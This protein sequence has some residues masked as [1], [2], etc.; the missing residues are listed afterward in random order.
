[1]AQDII[2]PYNFIPLSSWVFTPDWSEHT[3]HDIPFS[4]GI[5]GKINYK[6]VNS[7]P[8]CVGHRRDNNKVIWEK[9][10]A[11]EYIIPGSS[12]KGLL[13]TAMEIVSYGKMNM[14]HNKKHS[15]RLQ[16]DEVMGSNSTY[17]RLPVL[18]RP[19]KSCEGSWEY[20]E[21]ITISNHKP[22][23]A[24]VNDNILTKLGV[25]RK[26]PATDK[27]K[28]LM[29][30]A[31]DSSHMPLVYAK[32]ADCVKTVKQSGKTYTVTWKEVVD[33]SLEK[34]DEHNMPGMFLF[35]NE[36]I[37]NRNPLKVNKYTD[38]FFYIDDINKLDD[39]SKWKKFSEKSRLMAEL[40]ES[41]PAVKASKDG[42]KDDNLFDYYRKHMHPKAG[43]PVWYLFDESNESNSCTGFC[44]VMRKNYN[45]SIGKLITNQQSNV[46]SNKPDLPETIFGYTGLGSDVSSS[47]GRVGFSDL[48]GGTGINCFPREFILGEPK[49]SFYPVYLGRFIFRKPYDDNSLI[50]G[51]KIYKI[52]DKLAN[53]N[54]NNNENVKTEVNFIG[55]GAEFS[56]SITFH[57]LKPEELG[58]ILWV[59]TFG[60]G[61]TESSE[62]YHTLG[63]AKPMGAGAIQF[64]LNKNSIEIP[65]YMMDGCDV[66]ISDER[67][68]KDELIEKCI[69]RFKKLMNL[70]FPFGSKDNFNEW[71]NS[72]IMQLYL[73]YS[74][75]DK[76]FN[77][78]K[79]YNHF[80]TTKNEEGE[81]DI[82]EFA[83]IQKDFYNT[84]KDK[85]YPGSNPNGK[86]SGDCVDV[87][88]S[89][90]K[91]NPLLAEQRKHNEQLRIEK[92]KKIHEAEEKLKKE[93]EEKLKK[94]K[95][96][97]EKIEASL[98]TSFEQLK[99]INRE[100]SPEE[101][102][103]SVI[104]I[105]VLEKA[106]K[107][108]DS[109]LK[110]GFDDVSN[111]NQLAKNFIVKHQLSDQTIEDVV[112]CINNS[113]DKDFIK[114][115]KDVC[116]KRKDKDAFKNLEKIMKKL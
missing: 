83:I 96:E 103:K 109:V 56:G 89:E 68:S 100:N 48:S 33:F 29:D 54:C 11:G 17:T 14:F 22:L 8:I 5:S 111:F 37:S 71:E 95:E 6:I 77:E 69:S 115:I 85:K 84:L 112:Q 98:Q 1:M 113:N 86:N 74:K 13:R 51:R 65:E 25:N 19:D 47:G 38:Y 16:I 105:L 67:I 49:S 45:N 93:A 73:Y 28:A 76:D 18:V 24:S 63:S 40:K 92:L 82:N 107:K 114:S 59:M 20:M 104:D 4:D 21:T 106:L 108:T 10:P 94:K 23:S 55:K 9:N 43:F 46:D 27:I 44:Q 58:A 36:N 53:S 15:R 30:Y 64:K 12:I 80:P 75:V 57:N 99:A 34:D 91:Y 3:Y 26:T 7:T 101:F 66:L 97:K 88:T 52:R 102:I 116:K 35:M 50:A 32:L 2:V 41:L 87:V 81:K 90:S 31:N 78:D 62:Y 72:K 60:E 70:N 110:Q 42:N 61:V 39:Q 79:V